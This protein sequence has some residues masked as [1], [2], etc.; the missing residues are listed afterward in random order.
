MK[1]PRTRR[2][3]RQTAQRHFGHGKAHCIKVLKQLS[4]YIDDELDTQICAE[5]RRHLGA[6]PNCEEFI[7]SLRHTV[8]LC[9]H[10]RPQLLSGSDRAELRAR[11]LRAAA[12]A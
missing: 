3:R 12:S 10:H 2:P 6:C 11:I 4:A 1:T 5:I 8:H 9:R 7:E